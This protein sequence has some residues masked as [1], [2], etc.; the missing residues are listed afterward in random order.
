MNCRLCDCGMSFRKENR[1]ICCFYC[2]DRDK[3]SSVCNRVTFYQ[4]EERIIK[5]CS[6]II[7]ED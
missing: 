2:S 6:N 7:I 4:T 5:N 3:C 1:N